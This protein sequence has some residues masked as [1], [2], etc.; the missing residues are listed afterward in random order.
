[1]TWNYRLLDDGGQ[2]EVWDHTARSGDS[3]VA[4]V[5]LHRPRSRSDE[6][7]VKDVM[8][9]QIDAA[10][11]AGDVDRAVRIAR[12]GSTDQIERGAP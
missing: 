1:M 5:D 11:S 3:P 10:V 12:D 8:A 9:D 2:M 6:Q 7:V 4:V